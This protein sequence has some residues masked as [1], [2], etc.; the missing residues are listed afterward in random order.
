MNRKGISVHAMK[1]YWE[2][3]LQ[4]HSFLT[5]ELSRLGR[6]RPGEGAAGAHWSGGWLSPKAGLDA[7]EKSA[8]SLTGI[9]L[10]TTTPSVHPVASSLHPLRYPV[11]FQL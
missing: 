1:A 8:L 6:F 9:E 11:F 3:Q 2:L 10:T 7:S 5:L 4:L